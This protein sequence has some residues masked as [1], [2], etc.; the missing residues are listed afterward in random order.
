[1][2]GW[3]RAS[4]PQKK[5]ERIVDAYGQLLERDG[6]I[7]NREDV[8][9]YPKHVIKEALE[10]LMETADYQ[11]FNFLTGGHQ[12]LTGYQKADPW[13]AMGRDA[14]EKSREEGRQFLEI[15]NAIRQRR[16][17]D[18]ERDALNAR[19]LADTESL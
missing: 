3:R 4:S 5:A 15:T 6:S 13:S 19:L 8:L 16:F 1:M 17:P 12:L 7:L 9:P 11:R 18:P 10:L 14:M 2:F